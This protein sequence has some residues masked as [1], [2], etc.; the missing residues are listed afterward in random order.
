MLSDKYNDRFLKR[1]F[2]YSDIMCMSEVYFSINKGERYNGA[3]FLAPY[4]ILFLAEDFVEKIIIS[5]LKIVNK[6]QDFGL[7]MLSLKVNGSDIKLLFPTEYD[8]EI[9]LERLNLVDSVN[10]EDSFYSDKNKSVEIENE[11]EEPKKNG[12]LPYEELKQLKE[13]LDMGILTQEEFDKKKAQLLDNY[14]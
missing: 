8:K 2:F 6:R 13:L 11:P 7:P 5:R 4:S 12:T 1:G 3:V 9:F 10:L 14:L